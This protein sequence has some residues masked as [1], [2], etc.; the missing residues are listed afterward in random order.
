HSL[1]PTLG[2]DRSLFLTDLE[3]VDAQPLSEL[4]LARLRTR[5]QH[6]V[7]QRVAAEWRRPSDGWRQPLRWTVV[8]VLD[9]L[10]RW[11]AALPGLLRGDFIFTLALWVAVFSVAAAVVAQ[12]TI[13]LPVPFE[14]AG[15]VGLLNVLLDAFAVVMTMLLVVHLT[16]AV[17][18]AQQAITRQGL[19]AAL[20][21]SLARVRDEEAL[22]AQL[23]GQAP[24]LAPACAWA[25]WI[26]EPST[27]EF[28]AV[29]WAGLP[30]GELPGFSFT[31]TLGSDKN[32]PVLINGPL[33]GTS[34]GECTLLQPAAAEG[35]L[36]GLIT[37]AGRP[38][39]LGPETRTTVRA[40][41]EEMA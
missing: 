20:V 32:A 6:S 24:A 37:V 10:R 18:G 8:A 4:D 7:L 38:L 21:S 27:D 15:H 40:V 30:E 28:R 39:E 33:P 22:F 3:P 35:E 34:A 41:A 26:R 5:V 9:E 14:V 29:R 17:A 31:P 13:P 16:T 12:P 11:Q 2:P 36:T 1:W 23:A 19:M 25:F